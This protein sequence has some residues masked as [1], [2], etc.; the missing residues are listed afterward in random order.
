[1]TVMT[2]A[3]QLFTF[4]PFTR[5]MHAQLAGIFVL[6][7]MWIPSAVIAGW[8]LW[9]FASLRAGV[10]PWRCGAR[11]RRWR[12]LLSILVLLAFLLTSI[13]TSV[14]VRYYTVLYPLLLLASL[15]AGASLPVSA[16]WRRGFLGCIII[17][18]GASNFRTVDPVSR[19]A[20]GTFRFGSHRLLA[21]NSINAE[22][23]GFGIDQLVYNFEFVRLHEAIEA[24]LVEL[25]P[26]GVTPIVVADEM[27]WYLMARMNATTCRRTLAGDGTKRV[28]HLDLRDLKLR[29]YPPRDFHFVAL[30]NVDNGPSIDAL[31]S[32]YAVTAVATHGQ[33]GYL[34]TSY[35][36]QKRH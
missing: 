27:D 33:D 19:Y 3:H 21:M 12:C 22:R 30:P 13:R 5:R 9:R 24:A 36:M 23:C 17:A 28:P 20:Y 6:Q 25:R 10:R 18:F 11:T 4:A 14:S 29:K 1:L 34:L 31:R 26:S 2:I 35:R 15:V 7:F 32:Q 16:A 8:I